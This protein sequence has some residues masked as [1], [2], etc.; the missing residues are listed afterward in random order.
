ML[1]E[2]AQHFPRRIRSS[3][4]SVGARGATSRPCVSSSVNVPVLKDSAPARVGMD[5]SGIGMPSRHPPAMRLLFRARRFHELLENLI[6]VARMDRNVAIAV[7]NDGRDRCPV[8][9]NCVGIG[10]ATLSHGDE[11]GGKVNRGPTGKAGMYAD[12]CIHIVVCCPHDSRRR[13]SGRQST[14]IDAL[15]I[16]RIV[17]HDLAGDSRD[18][19]RFASAPLLVGFAKPVPA[20]RLVCL[21]VLCRID[22]EAG[23]LFRNEVHPRTGGEIFRRLGAAVQHHDQRKRLAL[24]AAG[25]EKPVGTAS[26]RNTVGTFDEPC[27]LRHQ[28]R[29]G[30][31]GAPA[32]TSQSERRALPCAIEQLAEHARSNRRRPRWARTIRPLNGIGHRVKYWRLSSCWS[33]A[34]GAPCRVWRALTAEHALKEQSGLGELARAREACGFAHHVLVQHIVCLQ[35]LRW[36]GSR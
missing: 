26:R 3:R 33:D 16:N 9:W 24:I 8:T 22:H 35:S 34:T 30:R 25:D 11:R 4:I 2:K 15:W 18:K 10:P 6:A 1:E 28:V 31:R 23:L 32:H 5:R 13:C 36:R 12:C 19:R 20:L 17:A 27:A 14:D 7:K 21:A 29:S